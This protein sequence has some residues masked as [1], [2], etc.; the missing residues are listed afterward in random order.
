M[1]FTAQEEYGLRIALQM[2]R[3][4]GEGPLTIGD[5]AELESLT[6]AYVAKLMRVMRKGGIVVSARGQAGG[7]R[8][9]RPPALMSVADVLMVLDRRL[10]EPSYCQQYP[11]SSDSCVHLGDCS[12]R[13]LWRKLES[14][15]WYVLDK[16]TLADLVGLEK[17]TLVQLSSPLP[18][19][20]MS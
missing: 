5:L 13:A 4:D 1:R 8:L 15:L 12:I 16:T 2:A 6:S 9:A 17:E 20:H 3:R 10:Y 7:Y 14:S 18:V 11:G 19:A